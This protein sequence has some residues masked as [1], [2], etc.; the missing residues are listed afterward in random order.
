MS[1]ELDRQKKIYN[2]ATVCALAATTAAATTAV[3]VDLNEITS[4]HNPSL[5]DVRA[6]ANLEKVLFVLLQAQ[7]EQQLFHIRIPF[8][9]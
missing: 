1:E 4:N 7:L 6:V 3:G 2:A 9:V 5:G 8:D